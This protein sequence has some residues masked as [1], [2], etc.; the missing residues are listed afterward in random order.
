M[1]FEVVCF[2]FEFVVIVLLVAGWLL[3]CCDL[4][5]FGCGFVRTYVAGLLLS[6]FA[7]CWYLCGLCLCCVAV[8]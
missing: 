1:L 3:G 7:F 2:L 8:V 6:W 4:V 5:D